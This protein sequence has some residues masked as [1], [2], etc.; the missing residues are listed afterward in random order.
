MGSWQTFIIA[1]P[2]LA[3]A[4]HVYT[5][6]FTALQQIVA[7]VTVAIAASAPTVTIQTTIGHES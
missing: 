3:K 5:G 1:A 2:K 7:Y 6:D 4:L